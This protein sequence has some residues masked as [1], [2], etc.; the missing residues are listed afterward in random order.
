[1]NGEHLKIVFDLRFKA[2]NRK[3]VVRD[4]LEKVDAY[5][6]IEAPLVVVTPNVDH[7]VRLDRDRELKKIYSSAEVIVADGFPIILA[8]KILGARL[9]E[10]VTG[11][12]L[13]VDLCYEISRRSGS[14]F[15]LGGKPGDEN[16]LKFRMEKKFPGLKVLV[17]APSMQFVPDG[18]EANDA[19]ERINSSAA[20]VLFVCLGF[21]KQDLFSLLNREKL[22]VPV[23]MGVGAAMEFAIGDIK[24][25]PRG[26]QIIGCEWLWR[27]CSNPKRL[28]RRYLI[29]DMAFL[30]VLGK[31]IWKGVRKSIL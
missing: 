4:L 19:I 29:D 15:I 17:M 21:P 20:D 9:P 23:S 30:L 1:M 11:A 16:R 7:V 27:L 3:E 5:N 6:W 22:R 13:F 18:Q 25:A 12:D 24:R 8:S 28:W 14:V 2:A 26:V 31:E 10:R